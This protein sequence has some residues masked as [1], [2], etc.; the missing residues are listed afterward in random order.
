MDEGRLAGQRHGLGGRHWRGDAVDQNLDSYAI[1]YTY[2]DGTKLFYSGRNMAGCHDEFSSFAH[3]TKGA[4]IISTS[5]HTPGKVRTFD[6]HHFSEK[7]TRWAFPQPEK[8]PYR[9]EWED[10]IAAI[11]KGLPYS[12]V[13][14]GAMASLVTVMGRMA[15]HTGQIVTLDEAMNHPHEFAPDVDKLTMD[16]PAPLRYESDGKYPVP[17]PGMKKG[18]EY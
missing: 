14:R 6:G 18:R 9:L 5:A 10:L 16:S 13:K 12:E 11:R 8:S 17:M 15:A 4:A 1:E 2:P 3:G 7:E